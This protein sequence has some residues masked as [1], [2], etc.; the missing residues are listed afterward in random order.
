MKTVGQE[1]ARN[2][3][4]YIMFEDT[5]NQCLTKLNYAISY[6]NNMSATERSTF[7]TSDDYVISIARDRFDK[8]LISQGKSVSIS[9]GDYVITANKNIVAALRSNNYTYLIITLTGVISISMVGFYFLLKKKKS[10]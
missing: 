4:N 10:R 6:F 8:W 2:T 5:N 7:M 9:G 3:A 1:T